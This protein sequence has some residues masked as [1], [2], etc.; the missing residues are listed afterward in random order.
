MALTDKINDGF[1]HLATLLKGKVDKTAVIDVAHGG[2]GANTLANA[3]TALGIVDNKL[4]L[5]QKIGT[6]KN[7]YLFILTSSFSILS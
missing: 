7:S 6:F 3:Q 1:K 4:L 2:T 5:P